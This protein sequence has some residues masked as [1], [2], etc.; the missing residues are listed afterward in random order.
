MAAVVHLL[1]RQIIENHSLKLGSEARNE[2]AALLYDF[3]MSPGFSDLLNRLVKLTDDLVALDAK[4]ADAHTTTW[5]KRGELIRGVRQVHD[6]FAEAVS[7][8]T[9]GSGSST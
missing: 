4:E 8:I 1:R 6:E 5:K 2:K 9:H 7:R 3:I